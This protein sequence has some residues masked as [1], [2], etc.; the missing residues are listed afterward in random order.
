MTTA[1]AKNVTAIRSTPTFG[2]SCSHQKL[3]HAR[4]TLQDLLRCYTAI[5]Y[6]FSVIVIVRFP[7]FLPLCVC[8]FSSRCAFSPFVILTPRRF[9]SYIGVEISFFLFCFALTSIVS[10][11][12]DFQRKRQSCLRL[13]CDIKTQADGASSTMTYQTAFHTPQKQTPRR[14]R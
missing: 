4:K 10:L 5:R 11:Y 12:C 3:T 1:T 6:S 2:N 8:A 14:Q 9:S 13:M 7:F